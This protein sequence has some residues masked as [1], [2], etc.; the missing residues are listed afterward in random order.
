MLI[1]IQCGNLLRARLE[2]KLLNM[3]HI[4]KKTE[5]KREQTLMKEIQELEDK[6]AN[7]EPESKQTNIEL[8]MKKQELENITDIKINGMMIRS[9]AQNVE[10][11]EK[12][13]NTSQT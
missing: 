11:N 8:N 5:L 4:K 9:K 12:I 1:Q 2:M 6:L 3:Q 7:N 10:G 13:A